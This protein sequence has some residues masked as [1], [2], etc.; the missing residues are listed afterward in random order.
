ML[1]TV[2]YFRVPVIIKVSAGRRKKKVVEQEWRESYA[3]DCAGTIERYFLSQTPPIEKC[4]HGVYIGCEPEAVLDDEG[5]FVEWETADCSL[6]RAPEWRPRVKLLSK[7]LG[8]GRIWLCRRPNVEKWPRRGWRTI[9]LTGHSEYDDEGG[10]IYYPP[11]HFV[12][13]YDPKFRFYKAEAMGG[14]VCAGY[15]DDGIAIK[16]P[17]G[18]GT[19]VNDDDMRNHS[20]RPSGIP[21][22]VRMPRA[23]SPMWYA[24]L[25]RPDLR[26]FFVTRDITTYVPSPVLLFIGERQ[27]TVSRWWIDHSVEGVETRR[28]WRTA[29]TD[30]EDC[31][32]SRELRPESSSLG[33][34]LEY[35]HSPASCNWL[36]SV[37]F[38]P[39]AVPKL[40]PI[41]RWS[42]DERWPDKWRSERK[43]RDLAAKLKMY[44]Y[45]DG[46]LEVARMCE[47]ASKN[48]HE[49]WLSK[50]RVCGIVH[51]NR[52]WPNG[53]GR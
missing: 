50:Q 22:S 3:T 49:A 33:S 52:F 13:P 4:P 26:Q 14:Y 39:P 35:R 15:G 44:R 23:D 12:S 24:R 10:F 47:T 42:W 51:K 45:G 38:A 2:Q 31:Q 25:H 53:E 7:V 16:A 9:D 6:C 8:V 21:G 29:L 11:D 17:L 20:Q 19:R 27:R 32:L 1:K 36:R 30:R 5:E 18:W 28:K 37:G 34:T 43:M 41:R 40:V 48:Q 46:H